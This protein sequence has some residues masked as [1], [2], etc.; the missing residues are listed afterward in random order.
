[1]KLDVGPVGRLGGYGT[2]TGKI[3]GILKSRLVTDLVLP[4]ANFRNASDEMNILSEEET[5]LHPA[6]TLNEYQRA[7]FGVDEQ[8]VVSKIRE[9]FETA[10]RPIQPS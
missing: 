3:V 2:Q 1:M 8:R 7:A 5:T 10:V 4:L 6:R 9:R